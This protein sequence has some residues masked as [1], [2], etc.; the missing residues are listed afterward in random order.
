MKI[1]NP[2]D[3]FFKE[4]FGDIAVARDFLNHYLPTE[5][6]RQVDMK[7]L[8][9][10][11]DSFV[12][13]D[14]EEN[15]SDLLFKAN[16]QGT[17]GYFYFL[18][19]HK[20]YPSKNIML[21]LLK[22]MTEIW[23]AKAQKENE[24]QLPLVIPLVMYHGKT[25]WNA[26]LRLKDM[27]QGN[28]NIPKEME[29]YIPDFEYLLFDFS[30]RSDEEILGEAM[31]KMYLVM[32]RAFSKTTDEDILPT[33]RKAL[34]YL[35]EF[36]SKEKGIDYLETMMRYVFSVHQNISEED[37]VHVVEQ[38]ETTYPEGGDVI[39]TLA[40]VYMEKG[41]KEG[42]EEG[43]KEGKREGKLEGKLEVTKNLLTKGFSVEDIV[44]VTGLEREQIEEI[45]SEIKD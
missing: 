11:K 4:T 38:I 22:Y 44:E 9:P 45:K 18:F 15:F 10:Q 35:E 5:L 24:W 40:E 34:Y 1:E 2:H 42:K 13:K 19:E 27:M 3:K 14:L 39:M 25:R 31:L 21:Q 20:S 16:F 29:N 8:E 33:I 23:D 6:I 41:K 43:K 26:P 12:N 30:H 32:I 37:L 17:E 28:T 7:S 36:E